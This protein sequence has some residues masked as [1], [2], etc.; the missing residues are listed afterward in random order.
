MYF[1]GTVR[2]A[3]A[4]SIQS[5]RLG[6]TGSVAE[7]RRNGAFPGDGERAGRLDIAWHAWIHVRLSFGHGWHV[8]SRRPYL[9]REL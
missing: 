9:H 4:S 6:T 2:F 3:R 5:G 1:P 8:P 7:V